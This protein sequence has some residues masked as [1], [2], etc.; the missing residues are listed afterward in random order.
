MSN[1]N[2]VI[3]SRGANE[4]AHDHHER[5]VDLRAHCSA[6]LDKKRCINCDLFM[7]SRCLAHN[8]VVPEEYIYEVNDCSEYKWDPIP[9]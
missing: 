3:A 5:L 9:F 1:R 8:T 4:S 6:E 7:Q 2:K